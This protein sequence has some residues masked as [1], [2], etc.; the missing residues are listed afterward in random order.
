MKKKDGQTHRRVCAASAHVG[1]ASTAISNNLLRVT[2]PL[3]QQLL[4]SQEAGR[5][6]A[7]VV[8]AVLQQYS[9]ARDNQT[10]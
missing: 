5:V 7:W 10:Q 1:A 8:V 9:R 4:P 3:R 2:H 6:D